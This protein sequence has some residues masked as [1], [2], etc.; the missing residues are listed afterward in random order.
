MYQ[1]V[2][3]YFI[4]IL[5]ITA[6]LAMPSH[7]IEFQ[8]LGFDAGSMGGAGVAAA[9]G[10]FAP[11]YNPALLPEQLNGFQMSVSTGIGIREVNVVDQI[12]LNRIHLVAQGKPGW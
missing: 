1:R 12:D 11:Y 5:A 3:S 6:M 8:S 4:I 7:A 10:S 9:K 2:M